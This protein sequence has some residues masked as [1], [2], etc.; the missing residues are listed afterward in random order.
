[1]IPQVAIDA[2]MS[3]PFVTIASDG[4]VIDQPKVHPRGAGS[5]SRVLGH[6]VRERKLLDL[7]TALAK[8]TIMPAQWLEK[9]VPAMAR[10]GRIHVGADADISVFDPATVKDNATFNRPLQASSGYRYV[11][12]GGKVMVANGKITPNLFPGVGIRRGDK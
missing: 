9:V 8:M 7:K 12:V 5:C 1:M 10:K 2:A 3:D 11:L 6:Y 4:M